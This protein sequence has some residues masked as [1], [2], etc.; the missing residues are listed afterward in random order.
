MAKR[1]SVSSPQTPVSQPL[2][3]DP[4]MEQVETNA[5]LE[6]ISKEIEMGNADEEQ[7]GSEEGEIEDTTPYQHPLPVKPYFDQFSTQSIPQLPQPKKRK[8]DN[9]QNGKT[10][11]SKKSRKKS[12]NKTVA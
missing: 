5:L 11:S 1:K 3:S 9:S 7:E 6:S 2:T 8:H 12:K 4:P 10:S